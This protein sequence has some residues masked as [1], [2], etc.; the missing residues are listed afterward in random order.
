MKETEK[1]NKTK[2][3]LDKMTTSEKVET[4]NSIKRLMERVKDGLLDLK[5]IMDDCGVG[6][7]IE[8]MIED[9]SFNCGYA[10]FILS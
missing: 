4:A 5:N 10:A 7:E 6:F 9:I 3:K 2:S 8:D 1:K